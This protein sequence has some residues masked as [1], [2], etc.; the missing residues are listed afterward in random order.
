M[1]GPSGWRVNQGKGALRRVLAVV[2]TPLN[3][4]SPYPLNIKLQK[5]LPG[6]TGE[7]TRWINVRA[8]LRPS[9]F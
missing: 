5:I 7:R 1:V 2:A 4:P 3:S 8:A 6:P 9:Q